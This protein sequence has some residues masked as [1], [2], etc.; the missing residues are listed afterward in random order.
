MAQIVPFN[1]VRPKENLAANFC[2]K[3]VEFYAKSELNDILKHNETSFVHIIKPNLLKDKSSPPTKRYQAVKKNY[4]SFRQK[5]VLIKDKKA[6]LYIYEIKNPNHSFCG[7]LAGISVEDYKNGLIKR[8]EDTIEKREKIFKNF[9]KIARFNSEPVL[10]T[11]NPSQNLTDLI[12]E[13]KTKSPTAE[14]TT[15]ENEC[16]KLWRIDAPKEILSIQKEYDT[17]SSL[18]IADGH[19]RSASSVLLSREE[20]SSSDKQR[21]DYFMG[22]IIPE[23]ELVIKAYNRVFS[24]LNG[25]SEDEFLGLLKADFEVYPESNVDSKE[26][27]KNSFRMYFKGQFYSVSLRDITRKRNNPLFGLD[28]Y[29][30]QEFILKPILGV[31]NPRNDKRLIYSV[32]DGGMLGIKSAVDSEKFTLGFGLKP[33][34]LTQLKMIADAGLVMP[35]KSTYIFPKLMSGITIYEF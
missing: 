22:Y 15:S 24:G 4:E 21:T 12:S 20:K 10:I 17:I 27:S 26:S 6:S 32:N 13:Y 11:H 30:L 7:I 33:V 8:H 25:L 3:S 16:H 5:G 18:Y 2:S 14:F 35:P 31:K 1:A 9:I 29:V 28:A 19:H 23:N 34:T